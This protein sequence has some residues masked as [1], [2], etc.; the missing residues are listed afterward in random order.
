MH[1]RRSVLDICATTNGESNSGAS[2]IYSLVLAKCAMETD[3]HEVPLLQRGMR[4]CSPYSED[5]SNAVS[6]VTV[7]ALIVLGA[8]AKARQQ[9]ERRRV[10]RCVHS[11]EFVSGVPRHHIPQNYGRIF[12]GTFDSITRNFVACGACYN[13]LH[14][15]RVKAG[16]NFHFDSTSPNLT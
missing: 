5:R 6:G 9:D 11:L 13:P 1:T 14:T 7:W 4:R 15:T 3:Y 2:G 8:V 10:H 16:K 12:Q